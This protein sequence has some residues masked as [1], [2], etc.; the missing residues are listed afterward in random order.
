MDYM[1]N[2]GTKVN[3][4][5]HANTLYNASGNFTP[6][7]YIPKVK[8]LLARFR[9]QRK[10]KRNAAKALLMTKRIITSQ[11]KVMEGFIYSLPTSLNTKTVK[12]NYTSN[13]VVY[14][15]LNKR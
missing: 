5:I 4:R 3:K 14:N 1:R 6:H 12:I 10:L 2:S 13:K 15:N 9:R 8:G 7:I 11:P